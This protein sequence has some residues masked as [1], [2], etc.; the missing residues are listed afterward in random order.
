[1]PYKPPL[2]ILSKNK[3]AKPAVV[4]SKERS[5]EYKI[6]MFTLPY[7]I[8]GLALGLALALV[9]CYFFLHEWSIKYLI[10]GPL[11]FAIL[12][13]LTGRFFYRSDK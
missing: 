12:G 9:Y 10:A 7:Q 6:S 8:K 3:T 4:L 1:M 5:E 2:E 11:V 13:W